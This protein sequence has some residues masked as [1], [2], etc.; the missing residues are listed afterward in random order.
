M[1]FL[2]IFGFLFTDLDG[3]G[4]KREFEVFISWISVL[5]KILVSYLGTLS[6]LADY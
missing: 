5:F 3:G 1:K 4:E 2:S 6:I